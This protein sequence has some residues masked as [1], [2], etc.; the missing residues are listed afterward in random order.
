M[1]SS[2]KLI[3]HFIENVRVQHDDF[4]VLPCL[5]EF[6]VQSFVL[7]RGADIPLV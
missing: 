6:I 5:R 1:P 4:Q 7:F 2:A 3:K